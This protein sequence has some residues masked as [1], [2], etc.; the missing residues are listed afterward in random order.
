MFDAIDSDMRG[1]FV[2]RAFAPTWHRKA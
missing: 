1:T 2:G